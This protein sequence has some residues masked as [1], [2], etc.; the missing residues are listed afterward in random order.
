MMEEIKYTCEFYGSTPGDVKV[1]DKLVISGLATV[2][3]IAG[4]LIN[5]TALG[6]STE[7]TLGG[8][9]INL[10]SNNLVAMRHH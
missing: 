6:S 10:F 8:I 2:Q 5:I 4:D 9:T 7:V 1:G 3:S